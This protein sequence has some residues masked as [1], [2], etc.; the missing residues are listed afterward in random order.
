MSSRFCFLAF[1]FFLE[2]KPVRLTPPDMDSGER[3]LSAGTVDVRFD[4]PNSA[5]LVLQVRAVEAGRMLV[6][7]FA[8]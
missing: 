8:T 1:S 6:G 7:G 4:F 3:N 2:G 5:E